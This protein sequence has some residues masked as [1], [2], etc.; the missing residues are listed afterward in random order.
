MTTIYT[1]GFLLLKNRL[2]G[3]FNFFNPRRKA[4]RPMEYRFSKTEHRSTRILLLRGAIAEDLPCNVVTD[5]RGTDTDPIP[6]EV[7]IGK[8]HP[9]NFVLSLPHTLWQ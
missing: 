4:L 2:N 3:S 8:V 7:D 1:C 9:S 5:D 6:L